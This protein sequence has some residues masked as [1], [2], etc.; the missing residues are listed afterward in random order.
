MSANILTETISLFITKN[1]IEFITA[2]SI[3]YKAK[4]INSTMPNNQ[5]SSI[6]CNIIQDVIRNNRN[7][8]L[9]RFR[10][11]QDLPNKVN[12]LYFLKNFYVK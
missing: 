3:I 2:T 8:E 7:M 5:L 11:L 10:K 1:P 9:N 4:E 12:K 6:L